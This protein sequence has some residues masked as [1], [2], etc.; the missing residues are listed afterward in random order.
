MSYGTDKSSGSIAESE[1]SSDSVGSGGDGGS[2]DTSSDSGGASSSSSGGGGSSDSGSGG[3]SFDVVN[4]SWVDAPLGDLVEISILT[5]DVVNTGNVDLQIT[6]I[7]GT[8]T[9]FSPVLPPPIA[10]GVGVTITLDAITDPG[11]AFTGTTFTVETDL[12]GSKNT[13]LL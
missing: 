2:S 6:W 10:L 1:A 3:A 4:V 5:Y 7:S 13:P 12:A 11:E 8:A 9:G